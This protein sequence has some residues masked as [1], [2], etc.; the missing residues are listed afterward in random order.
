M[1]EDD[2]RVLLQMYQTARELV[3]TKEQALQQ[4]LAWGAA[5]LIGAT[6]VVP[7]IIGAS[8]S[9]PWAPIPAWA[10]LVLVSAATTFQYAGESAN[11]ARLGAYA[12]RIEAVINGHASVAG[13]PLY[14]HWSKDTQ[15]WVRHQ[16]GASGA[17]W[18]LLGVGAQG[19]PFLF[20]RSSGNAAYWVLL[21]VVGII[22]S[23]VVPLLYGLRSAKQYEFAMQAKGWE[24]AALARKVAKK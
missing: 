18:A 24:E 4:V 20:A 5:L 7:N 14:E 3:T 2:L 16:L 17:A 8:K 9:A 21:W 15:H 19:T 12:H 1:R 23:V 22:V 6:V 11:L 13:I 10:L